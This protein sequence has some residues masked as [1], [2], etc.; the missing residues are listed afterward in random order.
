MNGNNSYQII[1]AIRG[2]I[3]LITL[4]AL[5]ALQ[6]FTRFGFDQTWPVLLI[7]FG[8]LSLMQRGAAPPRATQMPPVPPAPRGYTGTSYSGS[9]YSQ[10]P[11]GSNPPSSG[12]STPGGTV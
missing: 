8:L 4:G 2:P 6:N 9:P 10:P 7:V 3:T 11:A 12:S 5:F 1:R